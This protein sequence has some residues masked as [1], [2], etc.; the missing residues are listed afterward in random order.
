MA[1]G[2]G[3]NEERR[4]TLAERTANTRARHAGTPARTS[5]GTPAARGSH[6]TAD[7]HGKR[8][9]S[10]A[11]PPVDPPR[12]SSPPPPLRHCF[13]DAGTYGRQPALLLKWRSVSGSWEGLIVCAVPDETDGSWVVAEFWCASG[14]L[15]PA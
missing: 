3:H 9:A 4:E 13:Y 6:S 8:P 1:G 12:P 5:D 2:M 10:W 14:L 15:T 7:F 11:M